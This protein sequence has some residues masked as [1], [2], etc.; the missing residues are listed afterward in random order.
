M[1]EEQ[2]QHIVIEVIRRLAVR[3]G[4]DGSRGKLIVVFTGATAAFKEAIQQVRSI[5][6]DGYRVQ[7]LF[8]QAAEDLYGQVVREQLEGFPHIT[9]LDPARW[10]TALK[11][12]KAIVVP[13]LSINTVSKVALLIA[14]NIP[15]NLL[16]HALFMGKAVFAARNGADPDG[17]HWQNSLGSRTQ[18]PAL[19]QEY[20]ERLQC[21]ENY[22]CRLTDTLELERTVSVF[23]AKEKDTNVGQSDD[24]V[25]SDRAIL[26]HSGNILTATNVRY[27]HRL[28]A[29][30]RFPNAALITPL[31]RDLAVRYGVSLLGSEKS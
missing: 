3:L 2:L 5:I 4:A 7:L 6:L 23:L 15:T 10:F 21:V 22:G 16:L 18:R 28:G 29:D 27:A 20:L 26:D 30:L 25:R 17:G 14:D 9:M 19:R 31:A 1:K 13:L 8:S 12:S 24:N 11:E